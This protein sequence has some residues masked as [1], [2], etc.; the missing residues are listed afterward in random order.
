[1]VNAM[2]EKVFIG[3]NDMATFKCPACS[4]T[5]T[6]NVSRFRN[7]QKAVRVKCKCPCGHTYAVL[8]ERRKHIRKDTNFTGS[9]IHENGT[10]RGTMRILDLSRSGLKI[11]TNFPTQIN[12]GDKLRVE[13]TLDDRQHSQVTKEVIIRSVSGKSLGAEFTSLEHYDKLGSYLLFDFG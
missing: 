7:I 2:T 8:L 4:K 3:S 13:F 10:E 11:E 6:A 5:R 9:F 1:M 12:V